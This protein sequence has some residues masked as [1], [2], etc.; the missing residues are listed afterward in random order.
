MS[1]ERETQEKV[2]AGNNTHR[3]GKRGEG[4][5]NY[6]V[7]VIFVFITWFVVDLFCRLVGMDPVKAYMFIIAVEFFAHD[8]NE[9][10][11]KR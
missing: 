2:T 1:G 4:M 10:S 8:A 5:M 11:K 7:S 3:T 9:I 6:L